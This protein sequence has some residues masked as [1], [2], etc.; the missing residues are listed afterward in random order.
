MTQL[1]DGVLQP[2]GLRSTQFVILVAI[3]VD[4]TVRLPDLARTLNVDRSTL[5]RN[6][7]PL[8]RS[9]L[10]KTMPSRNGRASLVRLTAKGRRLLERTVPLWEEAQT[11]FESQLGTRRWKA[12]LGDL[13]KVVDAAHEA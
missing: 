12:L 5:T 6:L 8:E 4:Q 7:Q 1:F 9:G 11:R 2:S 10:L 13:T 3:Q